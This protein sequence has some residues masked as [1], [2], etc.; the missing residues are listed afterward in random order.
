MKKLSKL[1]IN[2]DRLMKNDELMT[3]RGGYG[4]I[5]ICN[6]EGYGC[7]VPVAWCPSF[8]EMKVAC[9]IGCPGTTI[10]MCFPN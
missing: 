1:Q 3:L 2:S 4:G 10:P 7:I 5:I 6:G 8:Q 9:N